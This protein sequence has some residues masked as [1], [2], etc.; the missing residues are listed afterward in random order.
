MNMNKMIIL[1]MNIKCN[2]VV[3]LMKY[4]IIQ[5][6]FLILKS[7]FLYL[8]IKQGKNKNRKGKKKTNKIKF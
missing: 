1:I 6:I 7:N 3:I 8:M 5:V 4:M 2:Q